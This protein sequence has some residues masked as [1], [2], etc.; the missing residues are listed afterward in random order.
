MHLIN[1]KED[2]VAKLPPKVL[3]SQDEWKAFKLQVTT[4][5]I[6]RSCNHEV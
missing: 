5:N 6:K 1:E 2:L 4:H 3:V